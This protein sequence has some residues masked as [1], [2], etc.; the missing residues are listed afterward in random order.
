MAASWRK[1]VSIRRGPRGLVIKRR[2]LDIG[3][4]RTPGEKLMPAG[5]RVPGDAAEPVRE[6]G[7]RVDVVD[8]GRSDQGV[9][10]RPVAGPSRRGKYPRPASRGNAAPRPCGGTFCGTD[11]AAAQ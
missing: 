8:P 11:A 4:R 2:R 3:L 10:C 7:L 9:D 5:G 6:P 1:V